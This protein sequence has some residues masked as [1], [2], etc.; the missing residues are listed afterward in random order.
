MTGDS[1]IFNVDLNDLLLVTGCRGFVAAAP[2]YTC[3]AWH[4]GCEDAVSGIQRGF[5]D[6]AFGHRWK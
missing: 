1:D 2:E 5:C 6:C 4:L 3:V